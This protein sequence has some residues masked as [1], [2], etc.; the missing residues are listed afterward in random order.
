MGEKEVDSEDVE[1]LC[2]AVSPNDEPCDFPACATSRTVVA[3]YANTVQ[4]VLQL[5]QLRFTAT[6]PDD[7]VSGSIG[8]WVNLRTHSPRA[9]EIPCLR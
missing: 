5:V 6:N 4:F 1:R 2:Q 8:S 7:V 3:A 9:T